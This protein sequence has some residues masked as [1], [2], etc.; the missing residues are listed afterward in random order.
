[1]LQSPFCFFRLREATFKFYKGSLPLFAWHSLSITPSKSR[2]PLKAFGIILCILALICL[3][4]WIPLAII[5]FPLLS[6]QASA[7][8]LSTLLDIR[9]FNSHLS[10][11]PHWAHFLLHHPHDGSLQLYS[12]PLLKDGEYLLFPLNAITPLNKILFRLSL[13]F[14]LLMQTETIKWLF[15]TKSVVEATALYKRRLNHQQTLN[16]TLESKPW[17]D[18]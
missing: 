10:Y 13:P 14:N 12:L 16:A 15:N 8:L 2:L 6:L 3:P 9:Q 17:I 7:L 18:A 11:H 5:S 1:M 4:I